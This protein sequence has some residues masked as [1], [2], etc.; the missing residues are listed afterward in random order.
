MVQEV[1]PDDLERVRLAVAQFR[2]EPARE[3]EIHN[4]FGNVTAYWRR[5]N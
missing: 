2:T 1:D 5:V 3:R 4:R